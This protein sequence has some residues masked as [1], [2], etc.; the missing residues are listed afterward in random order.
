VKRPLAIVA[1]VLGLVWLIATG[2]LLFYIADLAPI[3]A[4]LGAFVAM[5]GAFLL[6]LAMYLVTNTRRS[7]DAPDPYAQTTDELLRSAVLLPDGR[8]Y[9]RRDRDDRGVVE[10]LSDILEEEA[11]KRPPSTRTPPWAIEIASEQAPD[12]T[13][14]V[15]FLR[16]YDKEN[17]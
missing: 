1:A 17:P 2:V 8:P 11:A 9:G 4:L 10:R 3:Q 13:D 7:W 14:D 15:P 16:P 6:L 12:P 5:D